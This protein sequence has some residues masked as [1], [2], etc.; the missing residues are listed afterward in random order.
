MASL[1]EQI[2]YLE[3]HLTRERN[4]RTL[5]LY[6]LF[7]A[8]LALPELDPDGRLLRFAVS[9]LDANLAADILEDGVQ[10]ERST[11]YHHVVLRSFLGFRENARRFAIAVPPG[12]DQ[13]LI[14]ACEFALHCH[15]PDGAIPA[16][17][18]SDSGSYLDLLALAGSLFD[19]P[20]FTYVAARGTA[21]TPPR[22]RHASFPSGGYFVPR[23]G[24][25]DG[26]RALADER[27]L[28]FDC[29]PLGDGGHGH[30]DALSVEIA[31][32]GRPLVVDPGRYTYCDDPPHWRRWFKGTAAH[33]TVTVD[34]VDQTPYRRGKPK[35]PVARAHLLHRLT[36]GGLDILWGEAVSPAYD[37]VHRRRIVFIGG[38]YWLIEDRLTSP[39]K[40]RYQL[41]FHLAAGSLG[42]TTLGRSAC[43]AS[44]I[45]DGVAIV[46]ADG[47]SADVEDGWVSQE[48]GIKQP[49]P[50]ISIAVGDA[51][52]FTFLTLVAP[53]AAHDA[54]APQLT[55]IRDSDRCT[56]CVRHAGGRDQVTWA[57]D[58]R[59]AL[60]PGSR[61]A[62][63]ATL[64]AWRRT[65]ESGELLRDAALSIDDITCG[66]IAWHP[67]TEIC[68]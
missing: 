58:G 33:N 64:A 4:H 23:S 1:R 41:R 29:G 50:I 44:V 57:I 62:A 42:R 47:L 30:Y 56:A 66:A 13:R 19:R 38:E 48:Y 14:R 8:A 20:D 26:D 51:A 7:I 53:L 65:S 28:I 21:G 55:S 11:H 45:G 36:G 10:R 25:G 22:V 5:E 52:D 67:D 60:I 54:E 37:V 27:Y 17:S 68:R 6:A 2:A 59:D 3:A 49:A 32:G 24:W 63:T 43:C 40:H 9:S 34:G 12:F 46:L 31:A 18:D 39:R 16:L 61:P 15:R 35:G